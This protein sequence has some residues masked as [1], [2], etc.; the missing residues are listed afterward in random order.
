M[1][2]KFIKILKGEVIESWPSV[3]EES[4]ILLLN[5]AHVVLIMEFDTGTT[6]FRMISEDVIHV[7]KPVKELI[8]QLY[9]HD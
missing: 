8:S 1:E 7:N 9:L 4:E 6:K 3:I 2:T 5:P